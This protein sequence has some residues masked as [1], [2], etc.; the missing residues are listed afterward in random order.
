MMVTNMFY[1]LIW[2][3]C[4]IPLIDRPE[5]L[6]AFNI[7]MESY[8][9]MLWLVFQLFKNSLDPILMLVIHAISRRNE[10]EADAFSVEAGFGEAAYSGMVR[11]F[12]QNKDIVFTSEFHNFT[13]SDHPA[14]LDRLA[15]IEKMNKQRLDYSSA[16]EE[17]QPLG[18]VN[19]M[20]EG[21]RR[22]HN[23][24]KNASH[25]DESSGN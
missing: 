5:F 10:Y 15:R 4:M 18:S 1:V 14:L 2:S 16:N 17:P 23:R 24:L 20:A 9:M 7:R 8:W 12:A 3:A 25:T 22:E 19:F 6:A 13:Q 11:N 21:G